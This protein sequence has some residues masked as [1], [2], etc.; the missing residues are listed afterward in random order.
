MHRQVD[1]FLPDFRLLVCVA[2]PSC[3]GL[4]VSQIPRL[5]PSLAW[6]AVSLISTIPYL[7]HLFIFERL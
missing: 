3:L 7:C 1:I 4:L 6:L 2:I 5:C